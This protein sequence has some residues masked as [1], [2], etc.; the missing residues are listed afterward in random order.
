[1]PEEFPPLIQKA[2]EESEFHAENLF[3]AEVFFSPS[4][5]QPY[6]MPEFLLARNEALSVTRA[7]LLR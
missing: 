3:Y 7:L 1:M 2:S 5:R 6:P 4:K